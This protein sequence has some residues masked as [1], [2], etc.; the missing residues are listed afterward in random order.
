MNPKKDLKIPLRKKKRPFGR[1]IE[2]REYCNIISLT[3]LIKPNNRKGGDEEF[4]KSI[5][6]CHKRVRNSF[7]KETRHAI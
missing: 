4:L 5:N 1:N 3:G 7:L 2:T 6:E